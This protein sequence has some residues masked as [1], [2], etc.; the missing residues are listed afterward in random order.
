MKVIFYI[1]ILTLFGCTQG[2][3]VRKI[4]SSKANTKA[5]NVET[6]WVYKYDGSRQCGLGEVIS[7][8]KMKSELEDILIY[9]MEKR[10]DGLMH[11]MNCGAATG[12]AN[13]YQI[14]KKDLK[15]AQKLGFQVWSFSK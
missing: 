5:L 7:L 3:C 6:I 13:V 8:G 10:N 15:L 1:L 12:M 11:T 2:N 4:T 14:A 9:K